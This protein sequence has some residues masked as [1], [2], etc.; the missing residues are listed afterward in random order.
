MMT[1]ASNNA[2][3]IYDVPAQTGMNMAKGIAA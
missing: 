3:C 2:G 1:Q